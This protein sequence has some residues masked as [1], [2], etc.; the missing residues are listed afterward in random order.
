MARYDKYDPITGG[1]RA[2]VAAD[3]ADAD[4]G[5]IFGVGIDTN[6]K[7]VKGAG[8]TGVVGVLVVTSKPGRVG[9][10]KEIAVVDVMREGCITDFC[11]TDGNVGVDTGVA[12]TAYYANPTTGEISSTAAAGAIYV[13]FTVEPGRLE[14]NVNGTVHA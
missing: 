1:F 5:K 9:P 4:L 7:L 14:V 12:G 3:Y 10:T 6:G 8:N 13:G 11:P 2:A